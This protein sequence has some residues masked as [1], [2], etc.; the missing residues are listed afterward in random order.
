MLYSNYSHVNGKEALTR[1][2]S[3]Y[4]VMSDYVQFIPSP[5][6]EWPN[7]INH[8]RLLLNNWWRPWFRCSPEPVELSSFATAWLSSTQNLTTTLSQVPKPET[9]R[10]QHSGPSFRRLCTSNSC[11]FTATAS[12][13]SRGAYFRKPG[14]RVSTPLGAASA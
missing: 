12:E 13:Y 6:R 14:N 9:N 10:G 4:Q 2:L 3:L 1:I 8:F 5:E 7:G 11:C